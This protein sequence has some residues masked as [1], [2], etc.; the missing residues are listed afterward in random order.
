MSQKV[1]GL[2]FAPS[3]YRSTTHHLS[4]PLRNLRAASRRCLPCRTCKGDSGMNHCGSSKTLP[5]APPRRVTAEPDISAGTWFS[6]SRGWQP[7][8]RNTS[9]NLVTFFPSPCLEL[10]ESFSYS[11]L[12]SGTR[13]D[14][15]KVLLFSRNTCKSLADRFS[16]MT[17]ELTPYLQRT[18][19][20]QAANLGC[21]DI[22]KWMYQNIFAMVYLP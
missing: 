8:A 7:S 21:K 22:K 5:L 17:W 13:K 12:S 2:F 18:L 19:Y 3:E 20:A 15:Q 6:G 1:S 9:S 11:S 4:A 14:P 16:I 10:L